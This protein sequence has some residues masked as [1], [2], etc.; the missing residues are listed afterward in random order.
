MKA[1]IGDRIVI[2]SSVIDRPAREGRIVEVRHLDGSPPFLV[3]WSESGHRGLIFPGPE[4]H[5]VHVEHESSGAVTEA[6]PASAE[7]ARTA[8]T[9]GTAGERP[10]HIVTWH[11]DIHLFEEGDRTEA[12]AVLVSGVAHPLE[13]DGHASKRPGDFAVPEIGD[14]LAAGRALRQLAEQLLGTAADDIAGVEGHPV[15]LAD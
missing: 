9:T 5:V 4:A 11:V 7:T 13:A 8:G 6:E 3:E 1:S 14:E 10:G 2:A 12:H 15:L